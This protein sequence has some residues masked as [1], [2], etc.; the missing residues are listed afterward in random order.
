MRP[1]TTRALIGLLWDLDGTLS[2]SSGLGL[3][4]TNEVLLAHGHHPVTPEAYHAG[5][6]LTTPRRFAWHVTGDPDH[7]IGG[8]LGAAFD[9]LYVARVSAEATPLYPGVARMLG[10][11]ARGGAGWEARFGAVSNACGAYVRAVLAANGLAGAI[12]VALG[13]DEVPAAKPAPDGLLACA[14][15][16]GAPPA[17][18]VY[19]GDSPTDG[20]AARAAGM[21]SVGVGW[22]SHP[23]HALAPHFDEVVGSLPELEAALARVCAQL[24]APAGVEGR[25]AG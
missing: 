8:V 1:P 25:E 22:G 14:A 6:R 5:T 24:C 10:S 11:L 21:R 17:A 7:P 9:D 15:A 20:A 16:V 18:C 19:V 12:P 23:A 4:A 13:A 2:D 3:A